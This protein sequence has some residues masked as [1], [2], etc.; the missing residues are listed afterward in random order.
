MDGRVCLL[1]DMRCPLRLRPASLPRAMSPSRRWL[2]A[3]LPFLSRLR[4]YL[5]LRSDSALSTPT[6]ASGDLRRPHSDL[7]QDVL[8]A[9]SL[10]S[11]MPDAV[12]RRAV[13]DL[14]RICAAHLPLRVAQNDSTLRRAVPDGPLRRRGASRHR[15]G[16]IPVRSR[17]QGAASLRTPPM[18]SGV[19]PARVS[20]GVD[21]EKGQAARLDAA[22]SAR[23]A[24]VAGPARPSHL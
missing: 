18:R 13:S 12:S 14:P 2:V 3:T 11:R 15:N 23:G 22:R 8:E 10:R 7:R 6:P 16:R 9:A 19:L 1:P 4:L 5:P 21:G 20:G 24:R 17:V